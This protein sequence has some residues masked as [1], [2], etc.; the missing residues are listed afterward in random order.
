[1]TADAANHKTMNVNTAAAPVTIVAIGA[2]NRANKY[3]EYA[4]RHPE[5]LKLVGVVEINEIR[6]RTRR[7]RS[8][9]PRPSSLRSRSARSAA[10][11]CSA[12]C[13]ASSACGAL[14]MA[15]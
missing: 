3:L 6:R 11:A 10:S 14:N 4:V 15:M 9:A 5:R 1:M 8:N 12:L 13:R 7:R 2:G